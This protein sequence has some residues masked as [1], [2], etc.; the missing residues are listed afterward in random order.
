VN[1]QELAKRTYN[2]D[3]VLTDLE[4]LSNFLIGLAGEVIELG[5]VLNRPVSPARREYVK[6]EAGDVRWYIASIH[7]ALNLTEHQ[8]VPT[9]EEI[10]D[11]CYVASD[12]H[13]HEN[14]L[15]R[16]GELLE[17][18]KK[19]YWH[20]HPIEQHLLIGKLIKLRATWIGFVYASQLTPNDVEQANVAKLEKRFP[21]GFK[22]ADSLARLDVVKGGDSTK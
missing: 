21:D 18:L 3:I 7:T 8:T 2:S 11:A 22:S 15:Q 5:Q 20:H 6:D 17:Y 12:R 4:R 14:L 19:G 9:N 10:E 16:T 13:A 1:Y